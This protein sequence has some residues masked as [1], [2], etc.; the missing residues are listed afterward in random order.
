MKNTKETCSPFELGGV[1]PVIQYFSGES[2]YATLTSNEAQTD[3]SNVTFEP[4][5]R[6]NWHIHHGCQQ[7]LVCVGGE[8]WYQEWGKEP[9]KMVPG[10]VVEIPLDVKHWHGAT[11]DSW[12]A[13]LS[14]MSRTIPGNHEWLEPVNDEEYNKL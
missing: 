8:G 1:N 10:S 14:V 9:V 5:C 13:H 4:G 11:K 12:F 2:F 7:I 3:I 6:N